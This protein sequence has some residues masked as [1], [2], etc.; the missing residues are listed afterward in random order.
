MNF[1]IQD[2]ASLGRSCE[3]AAGFEP[4]EMDVHPLVPRSW[5]RHRIPL[6]STESAEHQEKQCDVCD[7]NPNPGRGSKAPSQQGARGASS[8]KTSGQRNSIAKP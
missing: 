4:G 7:A 8:T 3:A 2:M 6:G 1:I 5:L